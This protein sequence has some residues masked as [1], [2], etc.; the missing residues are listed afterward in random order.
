MTDL[1]SSTFAGKSPEE[2]TAT[3]FINALHKAQGELGATPSEW[4]I[5]GWKRKDDGS[6]D[7]AVLG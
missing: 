7:D 6:F 5:H 1:F 2:V 4:E 3:E